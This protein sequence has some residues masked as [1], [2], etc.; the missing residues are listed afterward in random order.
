MNLF[1]ASMIILSLFQIPELAFAMA[2]DEPHLM[3]VSE[4]RRPT[5]G[6]KRGRGG[7]GVQAS[8]D[9]L[10]AS[11]VISVS[12]FWIFLPAASYSFNLAGRV[13]GLRSCRSEQASPGD[14]GTFL[15][16]DA[17]GGDGLPDA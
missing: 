14:G 12:S 9:D 1:L 11:E 2:E 17:T 8:E 13:A 7:S 10:L 4:G 6:T 5:R 3:E 16:G 15:E